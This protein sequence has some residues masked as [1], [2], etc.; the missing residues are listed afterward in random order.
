MTDT[1]KTPTSA[2]GNWSVQKSK[3]KEKFPL[4]TDSDLHFE[5]GK[6]EEMLERIQVKTG[7][8]KEELATL[9]A[10]Y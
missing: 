5:D 6:K 10:K 1:N 9:I 7:K 2:A 8:T 4:L 3:L